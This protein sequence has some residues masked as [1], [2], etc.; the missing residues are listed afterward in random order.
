MT[1]SGVQDDV[2]LKQE[3]ESVWDEIKELESLG[4]KAKHE[5]IM[6]NGEELA[7]LAD[8]IKNSMF[9]DYKL[10]YSEKGEKHEEEAKATIEP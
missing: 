10:A 1:G 2:D 7:A 4:I 9:E 8:V 3:F 6:S 5:R